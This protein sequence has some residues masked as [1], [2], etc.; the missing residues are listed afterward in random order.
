MVDPWIVAAGVGAVMLVGELLHQR[1]IRRIAPLVF[2]PGPRGR[3]TRLTPLL[4]TLGAA[5][6]AW[7]LCTLWWV[8]PP[9]NFGGGKGPAEADI[10]HL[11]LVLDVS[12]SMRLADAGPERSIERRKRGRE[13]LQ[14]IFQ[15]VAMGRYRIS[16]VATY[17]GAI[18]VVIDTNDAE[19]VQNVL[20]DLPMHYA[21]KSGETQLFAGLEEAARI[22]AKWRE[23]STTIVVLS[24]GDTLPP[25]GM[26]VMPSS[27]AGALVVGV[28]DPA[29]GSF[30]GGR[31]SRQDVS[32]LRQMAVRLG[33][34]YHDGNEKHVP[35]GVLAAITA[36]GLNAPISRW[37][38]REYALLAILV[39]SA[40][41]ALIPMALARLG[42]RFQP[43]RRL[44]PVKATQDRLRA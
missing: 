24:D 6:L 7:G 12:P 1:R 43:G 26:P 25:T 33:G 29:Q 41:L 34:T 3:W 17:T 32:G 40:L 31:N 37:G 8:V 38:R 21:F 22:A 4:R 44:N 20:D 2:D 14:S 27:V 15:R 16:V 35:T 13:V 39:G 42:T 11:V 23:K 30:I 19:V 18:P 5:A 28:G 9:R 10:R 36:G